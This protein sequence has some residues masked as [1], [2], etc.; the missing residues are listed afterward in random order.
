M[1]GYD[2]DFFVI[3]G[4]SGGVRAARIAAGH[5]ARV[6]LAEGYRLGGTCVIRGCV[7]KKLYAYASRFVDDFEDAP[8]F[9]WSVGKP[10][11]SWP[12]L[13]AAKEK[14][15][16]RLSAIYRATLE[17]SGVAIHDCN[18]GIEGPHD[19]RL[20]TG[21]H[22]TA[23]H[24]LVA[25]GS[26]PDQHPDIP[27]IDLAISSNEIFDLPVFPNRLLAVGSGYIA[28]EF[29]SIFARLGSDVTVAFRGA[30]ILRG[31]DHDMRDGLT[32][33]LSEAGVMLRSRTLPTRLDRVAAGLRVEFS[34]GTTLEVDQ[35]LAATGRS[36]ATHGLGLETVGVA[37]DRYGAIAVDR[38]STSSVPSIHAVGDVT[39]RINLTPVAVRE[40]HAL[41]DTLFGSRESAVSHD[42]V[43]SA[44]F[45]TPEI[46]TVGLTEEAARDAYDVIDI[47][48]ASF[49]PIKATLS[50]RTE[51]TIMKIVVD[52]VSD[53]V[54]GVH[55]LGHEAGEMIQL[56]AIAVTM[57][58]KKADFDRTMAVHPTAAEELVT[59][60]NR[61]ARYLRGVTD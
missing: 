11:F 2:V 9:G 30:E 40:G 8:G 14:E 25:T 7:P 31:F 3:G 38:F 18:A 26:R 17:R 32:A 29:A 46:G 58:A 43:A 34:D 24:I 22:L 6:A 56:V 59:M 48:K 33:A 55:I 28:L 41:A 5:G 20:S 21:A 10:Q 45:S 36:P 61:T 16:S 23:A 37:L 44:V 27:G 1:A 15:V 47:Y 19:I 12:A 51:K 39:D 60:R 52:G 13:V 49:R 4:G 50:S 53:R 35:V 57:G 54:L 42:N